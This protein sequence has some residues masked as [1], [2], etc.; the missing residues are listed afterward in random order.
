MAPRSRQKD[1]AQ[2]TSP[3][4]E[5][6]VLGMRTRQ[7]GRNAGAGTSNIPP[8]PTAAHTASSGDQARGFAGLSSMIFIHGFHHLLT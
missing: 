5:D 6:P 2:E 1:T 8:P 7:A 3:A 4:P